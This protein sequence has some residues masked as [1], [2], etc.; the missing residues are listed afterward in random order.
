[1]KEEKMP[2][3]KSTKKPTISRKI[4][5]VPVVPVAVVHIAKDKNILDSL[6]KTN[7]TVTGMTITPTMAELMLATNTGNR[8]VGPSKVTEYASAMKHGDWRLTGETVIFSKQGILNDGQ[9]RL[10]ACIQA[11]VSFVTDVRFGVERDTFDCV[12]IGQKRSA[13]QVLG[14]EGEQNAAVLAGALRMLIS[15]RMKNYHLNIKGVQP[16]IIAEVLH[17]N[18][19]MRDSSARAQSTYREFKLIPPSALCLCHFLF[20]SI[21][22]EEADQFMLDLGA[23][24]SMK[25]DD[26][27][28]AL[29]R[30]AMNS[31]LTGKTASAFFVPLIIRTWNARR[32]G[33]DIKHLRSPTDSNWAHNFQHPA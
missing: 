7:Q 9:H 13:A 15:Y 29:R 27:V 12:D 30:F 2:L 19:K 6:L 16:S 4:K 33:I 23:G 20:A 10:L 25:K 32:A 5:S 22:K 1:M 31:P 24:V 14:I 26:P 21:N 17:K 18:P 8:T 28:M 11:Q 3:P